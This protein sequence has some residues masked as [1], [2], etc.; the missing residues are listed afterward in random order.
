[1]KLSRISLLNKKIRPNILYILIGLVLIAGLSTLAFT[2][3]NKK[4][5]RRSFGGEYKYV[6]SDT[7]FRLGNVFFGEYNSK[8]PVITIKDKDREI[9][10]SYLPEDGEQKDQ[11]DIQTS[12]TNQI[13]YYDI[14][15]NTNLK[16]TMDGKSAV[17]EE[18]ELTQKPKEE[19]DLKYIFQIKLTNLKI[20]KDQYGN[21]ASVFLSS[22]NEEYVLPPLFM[23]DKKGNRSNDVS[24]RLTQTN[25]GDETL[26]TAEVLPDMLWLLDEER[27][28]PVLIDPTIVKG[29]APNAYWKFDE[30]YGSTAHDASANANHGNL[31]A[32]ASPNIIRQ[33]INIIDTIVTASG[34]DPALVS[35]DTTKYNGTVLYYFEAVGTV[36]SGTL[37]LA[38]E[39]DGTATQDSTLSFTETSFTRKRSTAF[40]PPAGATTYNINLSGGTTPQVKAAR[41]VIIQENT[42]I[43][44]TQTQIEIGNKETAKTDTTLT[45]L[46]NPKYWK[47]TSANWDGTKSF[48][49][50][51]TYKTSGTNTASQTITSGS[52][53]WTAPRAVSSVQVEAWGAGGGGGVVG[54]SGGGGGGGG[55]YARTDAVAVSSGTSYPYVVGAGGTAD[56]AAAATDTTFNTTTVV[57]DSG[58]GTGTITGAAGGTTANSTGVD[59]E[60]AGSTGG[61]G[62]GTGDAG[63]GGGGAGGPAGAG[64][65]AGSATTSQGGIGGAGINGSGGA[66]GAADTND[67]TEPDGGDGTANATGG[68][69]GGGGDNG[70]HGGNGGAPGGGGGGGEI[71]G[72]QVGADGQIKL[73]W[74]SAV[75]F[76]LQEDNGSF[77]SWTNKATIL[78]S[79]TATSQTLVVSSS[80]TPTNGRNYRIVAARSDGG[81]TYD[82]Y[83]AKIVVTQTGTI[84]KL[85]PQYMLLN[86]A[87]SGSTGL[88][89]S[90]TLWDSTEWQLATNTY[91]YSHDSTDAA[92]S[93]KL[94]DISN[95]N[96]DITNATV[97]GANQQIGASAFTMPVTNHDLDT[98][99]TNTTGVVNASRIIVASV[100]GTDSATE[101]E[102]DWTTESNCKTNKCLFFNGDTDAVVVPNA[103]T[104]DLDDGLV[105]D[106]T[107]SM[108]VKPSS[109]GDGSAGEIFNAN[110]NTYAR[111]AAGSTD[112]VA[113]LLVSLDLTTSDATVTIDDALT[114][115]EWQQVS[116]TYIDDSEDEIKVYI[117]GIYKGT[118][119]NGDGTPQTTSDDFYIGGASTNNYHGYID[120]FAIYPEQR[121]QHQIIVGFAGGGSYG[122][123]VRFG[124][125][126]GG[127]TNGLVGYWK[128][129]EASGDA[130]DASGNGN[131]LTNN[132][133]TTYVTG[134]FGRGSEHVPASTQYL[135]YLSSQSTTYTVNYS[136]SG[137]TDASNAW[138]SDSL[139]F[140]TNISDGASVTVCASCTLVASGTNSPTSGSTILSVTA[141]VYSRINS[142]AEG[143]WSIYYSGAQLGSSG[144]HYLTAGWDSIVLS[145]PSG[146]WTWQKIN[147][148]ELRFSHLGTLETHAAYAYANEIIVESQA[149]ASLPSISSVSFWTNPDALTNYYI[150][151]S[152]TANIQSNASGVLSANGFTDP[153]IYVN[154]VDG[155]TLV[156][157]QWQLVTVTSTAPIT[158][159]DFSIGKIGTSYFDGTMDEV[160]LY[161]RVLS[162]NEIQKL[163]NWAP[164][165][166]GYWNMDEN[167]GTSIVDISGNGS[168]L[169]ATNSPGFAPGKFGSALNLVRSS[170]QYASRADNAILSQ[171]SD[172]TLSAWIRPSAVTASTLF[173]I[174]GKTTTSSISYLLTQYGDEI[175]MYIGSDSNY[176]TTNASNLSVNTWYH[177]EAVYTASAQTVEIYINGFIAASTTTGT[178]PTSIADGSDDFAVGYYSSLSGS[179]ALSPVPIVSAS[180]DDGY[181]NTSGVN[182]DVTNIE[183]RL[184][185]QSDPLVSGFR[186]TS[187]AI[188]QGS[189][190]TSATFK[191]TSIE[192]YD[193]GAC[194][195]S[196]NVGLQDA[197]DAATFSATNDDISARTVTT[198]QTTWN[199]TSLAA[200]V[201]Y[202]ID[203]TDAVQEVVDRVGWASGNDMAVLATDNGSS[204]AEWQNIYSWDHTT[205]SP[206]ELDISYASGSTNYYDGAVDEVKLYNYTRTQT[207]IIED[208]NGGHPVGGSPIG[209]QTAYWK[210]DEGYSTTLND[211]SPNS[212][213]VTLQT[214]T[215]TTSGKIGS[216][217]D[218]ESGS[219]NYATITDNAS[220]S[221][222]GSMTLSA[223]I[224]PESTTAATNFPIVSKGTSYALTQ[225]GDELRMYIGSESNYKTTNAVN[226]QTGTWYQVQGV[227]DS[228]GQTVTLYVN[229]VEYAG[230]VTGTIPASISDGT[231]NF[232]IGR[233][234]TSTTY[235][236]NLSSN[237][238]DGQTQSVN[239]WIDNV[240]YI[241][242]GY[243]TPGYND[244]SSGLRFPSINLAQGTTVTSAYLSIYGNTANSVGA[245]T[246]THA[247]IYIDD[248]DNAAAWSAVSNPPS[249]TTTAGNV[250]WDPASWSNTWINSPDITSMVNAVFG[251]GGWSSGNAMRFAILNDTTAG[252][253]IMAFE[254]STLAGG[255]PATLNLTVGAAPTY[256]DGVIDEIRVYASALSASQAK[257]EYSAGKGILMGSVSANSSN[258]AQ[259]GK[260]WSY[261][262]PGSAS[263]CTGPTHE[264][265]M[266]ENTSTTVY[267]TG[268][269]VTRLNG[270]LTLGPVFSPGKFGSGMTFDGTD[271]YIGFGASVELYQE[272]APFT[273]SFWLYPNNPS[274]NAPLISDNSDD[275]TAMA[276]IV[277]GW[278]GITDGL[279]Y[280]GGSGCTNMAS[281][282]NNVITDNTWQQITFTYDGTNAC[283]FYVNGIDVTS[284]GVCGEAAGTYTTRIGGLTTGPNSL[285]GSMDQ[286]RF[287]DYVRTPAQIAWE[288]NRGAPVAWYK[289]DEGADTV[290]NDSSGNGLTGTLTL[291]A[292]PSTATAWANG[293]A[294]KINSSMDFD[295]TDDYILVADNTA[296]DITKAIT[297]AAWVRPDTISACCHWIVNKDDTTS[298][299]SYGMFFA[300]NSK[301]SSYFFKSDSTAY[302]VD[303]DNNIVPTGQWSHVAVTYDTDTAVAQYYV[304]GKSVKTNIITSVSGPIQATTAEVTIGKRN[305][306]AS[307]WPFD[308]QIDDVRIFN[309]SLTAQ[310]I[311]DVYN[312]GAVSF[313]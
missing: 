268:N 101:T 113:D 192:T 179:T 235:Q 133:T 245:A 309:Y 224:K 202:S 187:I 103:S 294:G 156:A 143:S 299:R 288:Y 16:Y 161:N 22:D 26:L 242:F 234:N 55:A 231:S 296:L 9:K 283:R 154:G 191:P 211:T 63:G 284:D 269:A 93:S 173:P 78:A 123:A 305:Y 80:F 230:T 246:S 221:I 137:P 29:A 68:G 286:V 257:I 303:S 180:T 145:V 147:D 20:Q 115:Y 278:G 203:V 176:V 266:D 102:P 43:T 130:T 291:G 40:T 276:L 292:S 21:V 208:L 259:S 81:I 118:S 105:G 112:A 308:G 297:I 34:D 188:P 228:T 311:R 70:D 117:N 222:T 175:R 1:M 159:D 24:F 27:E 193:C 304:N 229:G 106:F 170:S 280:C 14:R 255:H 237:L 272:T 79:G 213:T 210:L 104:I 111:L 56:N 281:S 138:S 218:F 19:T 190:I 33:E 144:F 238:N 155:D 94:Q 158:V 313:K 163:Y 184:G 279:N 258:V 90:P 289:I 140:D 134:K 277:D 181:Q 168:S 298:Q 60:Y 91:K 84:T 270:T 197:D 287:Y 96:A 116:I 35:L 252:Q 256:Y 7:N 223:W 25:P 139:A 290:I 215:W 65:T 44:A 120:E 207:Q 201:Q 114:F 17:K 28:Y 64:G 241:G 164:G 306:F 142:G 219:S 248:V 183:I 157:N 62:N 89:S 100:L 6:Y 95:G 45:P 262:P 99:V 67:A 23:T 205:D 4:G 250:D 74:T 233:L 92:D 39:R 166:V 73:T 167:T 271:S 275:F 136:D 76:V 3:L 247:K 124:E 30:G 122:S 83:N 216:A 46:A 131:T 186:F 71:A 273:Y 285:E 265:S 59:A 177:V 146:G 310:Q 312:N 160:G 53:N 171:T 110:S 189:T 227:Y 77:G 206:A 153:S 236:F 307:N 109:L 85:E 194:T 249:V 107:I 209:S 5:I 119:A 244:V 295:G 196:V 149:A 61:N 178:I 42:G 240:N 293:A 243:Y 8:F 251:R 150:N 49:A 300:V 198:A 13:T 125:E 128:M 185:N 135:S 52:G 72:G 204:A 66:G 48:T 36:A 12:G 127:I 148:L 51:V 274:H 10:M 301:L 54:N 97:T 162:Q 264:Y 169:S 182:G 58:L 226:L 15:P 225:Y 41:I 88:Q 129:D 108:W 126:G 2:S 267:D 47:Y 217:L 18:I 69:G 132:G 152:S 98:N 87:D 172:L 214:G 212:N 31:G 263:T 195:L 151:F 75:E 260:E 32:P 254:D 165:P 199:I 302:Q 82:I 200:N 220:L 239:A 38:L 282:K 174:M 86:T 141:R 261:C 57:A 232:D 11:Y 121:T 37:T 253:N 50:S